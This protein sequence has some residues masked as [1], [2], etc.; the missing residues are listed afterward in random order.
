L[1]DGPRSATRKEDVMWIRL[2]SFAVKAGQQEQLR[3]IYNNQ[4]V[5]KVRACAGNVACLLLEPATA[6]DDEF[7]ACTI[8][9]SREDG[10]AYESS[11]AAREVVG[12]VR[13]YF[14]GPPVLKSYACESI[15]GIPVGC[16]G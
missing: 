8:W 14:A 5:P 7:I 11:G 4:A 3:A 2:G 12:L 16:V 9:A 15:A 1:E 13:Q 6:G 10:E